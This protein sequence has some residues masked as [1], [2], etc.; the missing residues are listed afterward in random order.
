MP[1]QPML[2]AINRAK[3]C[4]CTWVDIKGPLDIFDP[5][6]RQCIHGSTVRLATASD[7]PA[8]LAAEALAVSTDDLSV[9]DYE[10]REAERMRMK[11]LASDDVLTHEQG[12]RMSFGVMLDGGVVLRLA[13][14]ARRVREAEAVREEADH[15]GPDAE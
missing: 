9:V 2:Y 11:C 6:G 4:N 12:H 8:D 10:A 13:E 15:A 1:E 3:E 7:I 14:G 5:A